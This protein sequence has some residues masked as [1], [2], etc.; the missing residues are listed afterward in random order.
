MYVRCFRDDHELGL[1]I[2]IKIVQ[3]ACGRGRVSSRQITATFR[4]KV[5]YIPL[6]GDSQPQFT[7]RVVMVSALG[8]LV[9][10]NGSF[11]ADDRRPPGPDRA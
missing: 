9:S 3:L 8:E 7:T 10:P 5:Q 1:A 4:Q 11:Q 6:P 2:L